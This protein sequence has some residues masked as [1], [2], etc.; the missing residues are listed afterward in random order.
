MAV[1]PSG[2]ILELNVP[3]CALD[4][5]PEMGASKEMEERRLKYF[6]MDLML[7]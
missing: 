4:A 7:G 3:W 2:A 6:M 1:V 5:Q